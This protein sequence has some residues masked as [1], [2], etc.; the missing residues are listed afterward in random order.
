MDY[1]VKWKPIV[2]FI[3]LLNENVIQQLNY[4]FVLLK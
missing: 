4:N 1:G 2:D 3:K